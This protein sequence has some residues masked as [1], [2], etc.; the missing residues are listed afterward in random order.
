MVYQQVFA[1]LCMRTVTKLLAVSFLQRVLQFTGT[2]SEQILSQTNLGS[3][4]MRMHHQ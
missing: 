3:G 4:F 2:D 1:V